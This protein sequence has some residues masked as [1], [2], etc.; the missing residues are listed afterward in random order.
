MKK[1]IYRVPLYRNIV[2]RPAERHTATEIKEWSYGPPA[3]LSAKIAGLLLLR[4]MAVMICALYFA[5]RLVRKN[6]GGTNINGNRNIQIP[7][8]KNRHHEQENTDLVCNFI[9]GSL[10]NSDVSLPA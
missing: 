3:L 4:K 10:R 2:V 5:Q 1:N 8:R 6:T 7:T 9:T